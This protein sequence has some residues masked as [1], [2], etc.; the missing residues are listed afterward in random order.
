MGGCSKRQQK[1]TKAIKSKQTHFVNDVLPRKSQSKT[2]ENQGKPRK[3]KENLGK[4]RK[5][6]ENL[7]KPRKIMENLGKPRKIKENQGKSR[8]T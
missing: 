2:K 7:G 8:K 1:T 4:P 3:I 5:I 6:M